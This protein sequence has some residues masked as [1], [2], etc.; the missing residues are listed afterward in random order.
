M[1]GELV[2]ERGIAAGDGFEAVVEVEDDL[3]ERQLIGEQDAR[4]RGVLE[5][6]LLA[7]LLFHEL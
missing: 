7:A 4:R 6:D 2:V 3:V 5:V 1:A